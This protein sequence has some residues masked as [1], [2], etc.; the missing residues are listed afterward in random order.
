LL[1]LIEKGCE[2]CKEEQEETI[3]EEQA[4]TEQESDS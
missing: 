1:R 2:K 3:V 4:P